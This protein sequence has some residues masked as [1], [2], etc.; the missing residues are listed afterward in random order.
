MKGIQ[1]KIIVSQ[2]L[3][4]THLWVIPLQDKLS[5]FFSEYMAFSIYFSVGGGRKKRHR[6]RILTAEC[7]QKPKDGPRK[8]LAAGGRE[9]T[10]C[11]RVARHK[12]RSH[13]GLSVEH[14]RR[15]YHT[16]NKFARG[17]RLG[18]TLGRRKLMSQEGTNGTRNRDFE[19][20]LRLGSEG[21]TS[22]IYRKTI[23]LEFVK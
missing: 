8:K 23:G 3:Y 11:A 14:G 4:Y 18:Q 22:G 10:H 13:E 9:M 19:E 7:C 15:K 6:G 16:R 17:T 12:G 2:S 20:Q 5:K 1:T 21:T